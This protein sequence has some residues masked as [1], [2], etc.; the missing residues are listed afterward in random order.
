MEGDA[1]CGTRINL[2]NAFQYVSGADKYCL[3]LHITRYLVT[4]KSTVRKY[5]GRRWGGDGDI[6]IQFRK[7]MNDGERCTAMCMYCH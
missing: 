1:S 6:E 5:T 7:V 4:V 3:I 2:K